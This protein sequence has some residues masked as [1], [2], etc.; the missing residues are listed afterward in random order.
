[1]STY[2][3]VN[4]LVQKCPQNELERVETAD[5]YPTDEPE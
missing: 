5:I 4:E 3:I 2:G 1:M